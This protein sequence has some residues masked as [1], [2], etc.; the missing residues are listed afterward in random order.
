MASVVFEEIEDGGLLEANH[1]VECRGHDS[2]DLFPDGDG[3]RLE[4][5]LEGSGMP[6]EEAFFCLGYG[7]DRASGSSCNCHN[8]CVRGQSLV[9]PPWT[10]AVGSHTAGSPH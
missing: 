4:S 2:L 1:G 8:R 10:A 5:P 6:H 9:M 7:G 3:V